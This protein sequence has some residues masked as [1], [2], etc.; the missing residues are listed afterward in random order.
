MDPERRRY[1]PKKESKNKPRNKLKEHKVELAILDVRRHYDKKTMEYTGHEYLFVGISGALYQYIKRGFDPIV[2]G[3]RKN[4]KP[5]DPIK[6][7]GKIFPAKIKILKRRIENER[8]HIELAFIQPMNG[9]LIKE[10]SAITRTK[11]HER[12]RSRQNSIGRKMF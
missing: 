5:I 12:I 10:F 11:K 4:K 6:M 3:Q 1:K 7:Q 8:T 9:P 2:V